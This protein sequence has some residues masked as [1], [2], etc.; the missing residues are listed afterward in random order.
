MPPEQLPFLTVAIFVIAFLYS[1]V[2]HA[3]ASGYIAVMT[4]FGLT[5]GVIK[6][7]ALILNILVASIGTWQ[8]R[9]AGHFSWRLFWPFA[10]LAIPMAFFGGAKSLPP[11]VFNWLLGSVLLL[12]AVRFLFRL[13]DDSVEHDP[14]RWVAIPLGGGI[15]WLGGLTGTGG[16]VFL[17]PLMLFMRWANAKSAAAVT[18]PFILVVSVSG[19]LGKLSSTRS[20]PSFAVSLAVAAVMGGTAGSYLGSQRFNHTVIKRLLAV[21]LLIAG[22]KL[23][24]S[25]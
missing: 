21:T 7:T 23:I 9:R 1:S 14:P 19:L 2:G 17:T 24:F 11:Q 20:I 8:F 6:P 13:S 22:T 3:G 15:A 25:K 16:G 4:L 10:V 5:Q 18:A 12:S